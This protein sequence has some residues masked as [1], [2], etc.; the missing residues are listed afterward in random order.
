MRSEFWRGRIRSRM[1]SL[2][3]VTGKL[4][5]RAFPTP[6]IVPIGRMHGCNFTPLRPNGCWDRI[7][8]RETI[9]VERN[10]P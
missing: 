5:C 7:S 1:S 9:T 6:N 2:L 10:V 3:A 4:A 8:D